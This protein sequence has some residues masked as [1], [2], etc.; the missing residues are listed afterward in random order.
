MKHRQSVPASILGAHIPHR[1]V[2]RRPGSGSPMARFTRTQQ[3][4][5]TGVLIIAAVLVVAFYAALLALVVGVWVARNDVTVRIALTVFALAWFW[6]IAHA[7]SWRRARRNAMP[8]P[9]VPV[10]GGSDG[11][12]GDGPDAD[13]DLT[14]FERPSASEAVPHL[15]AGHHGR[16]AP[17]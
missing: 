3:A 9:E 4:L 2:T 11:S 14:I 12:E 10:A 7:L 5:E 6:P 16:A 1:A 13:V 15:D 17:V 8:H